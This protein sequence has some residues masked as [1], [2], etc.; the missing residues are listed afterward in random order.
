LGATH[1]GDE[2]HQEHQ[3]CSGEEKVNSKHIYDERAGNN[4]DRQHISSLTPGEWDGYYKA[5]AFLIE[6]IMIDLEE[7]SS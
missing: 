3:T 6:D 2:G 1:Y 7:L 4:N 5:G